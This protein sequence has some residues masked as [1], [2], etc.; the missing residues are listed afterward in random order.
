MASWHGYLECDKP[1]V[2]LR[3]PMPSH[4]IPSHPIPSHIM[5]SHIKDSIG[6]HYV[7][8]C[9]FMRGEYTMSVQVYCIVS[10]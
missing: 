5:Y 8:C 4:A 3:D 10:C 9:L 1:S 2:F 6:L 7:Q